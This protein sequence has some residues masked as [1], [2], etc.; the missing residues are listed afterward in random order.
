MA[1]PVPDQSAAVRVAIRARYVPDQAAD[2][3]NHGGGLTA[4]ARSK[5]NHGQ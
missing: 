4:S 3:G 1:P 2:H 5:I